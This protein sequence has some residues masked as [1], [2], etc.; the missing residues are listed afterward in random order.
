[1]L[2]IKKLIEAN[3]S[4]LL[5]MKPSVST[6]EYKENFGFKLKNT[7][8]IY[9]SKKTHHS[10]KNWFAFKSAEESLAKLLKV[11]QESD[12]N[13]LIV[14]IV[15]TITAGRVHCHLVLT[16]EAWKNILADKATHVH[17][18][19]QMYSKF[20]KDHITMNMSSDSAYEEAMQEESDRI[21]LLTSTGNGS[22]A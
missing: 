7:W 16:D 6:T 10:G 1:M 3:P 12:G 11:E 15:E 2:N 21:T 17:K 20:F 14:Y 9:E 13:L 18:V 4:G 19:H 5:E 8:E 22:W